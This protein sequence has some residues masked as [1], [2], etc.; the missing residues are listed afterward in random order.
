M[1]CSALAKKTVKFL[2]EHV[3]LS[4]NIRFFVIVKNYWFFAWEFVRVNCQLLVL[5]SLVFFRSN[6]QNEHKQTD[7][8]NW[9]TNLSL[10]KKQRM[11]R[12][13]H[14]KTHPFQKTHTE[15]GSKKT[16]HVPNFPASFRMDTLGL[17]HLWHWIPININ[18][19]FPLLEGETTI[20]SIS[21]KF[22]WAISASS[23][24]TLPSMPP[25]FS[26]NKWVSNG[27]HYLLQEGSQGFSGFAR[28]N[29][30]HVPL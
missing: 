16:S 27:G 14:P 9:R 30:R 22:L 5:R 10:S 24:P 13:K 20:I 1:E 2:D 25:I 19:H 29:V 21:S 18:I 12:M 4:A 23:F 28:F 7:K 6:F 11:T 15:V 8:Y 17:C 26:A 3:R